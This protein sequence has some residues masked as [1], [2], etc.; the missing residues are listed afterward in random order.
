M[1]AALLAAG[2]VGGVFVRADGRYREL[3][4]GGYALGWVVAYIVVMVWV[5]MHTSPADCTTSNPC[6]TPAE[7]F[8]AG[9][10]AAFAAVAVML[11]ALGGRVG[12]RRLRAPA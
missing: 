12:R 5:N 9:I 4:I 3:A 8:G 11:G 2:I 6:D 7:G 10:F 1:L